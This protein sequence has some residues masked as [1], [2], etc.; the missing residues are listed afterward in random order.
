MFFDLTFNPSLLDSKLPAL[1]GPS[2]GYAL[3]DEFAKYMDHMLS[4]CSKQAELVSK[5]FVPDVHAMTMFLEKV[6]EDCISEYLNAVITAAKA[7]EGLIIYLH[8]IASS[9]YSCSQLINLLAKNP[10]GVFIEKDNLRKRVSDMFSPY[11]S[12]Y[13]DL[14]LDHLRKRCKTEIDKWDKR[15]Q[16][17]KV[18]VDDKKNKGM[19][20]SVKAM[21]MA[22]VALLGGGM[23][24]GQSQ[25]LLNDIANDHIIPDKKATAT[26]DIAD[27]SMNSLVSVELALHLM[28]TNKESLGRV[29]V[30]TANTDMTKLRNAVQK[31]F[32][33]LL[34]V[35]GEK[36]LKPAFAMY[37]KR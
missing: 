28:H 27:Q 20:G 32:V 29:L 14:E 21:V 4:N 35:L 11:M 18:A 24:R 8:S 23:K 30:I 37:D 10:Y 7:R 22:P 34:K 26:Y 17:S 5:V 3:A 6:F 12:T 2:M 1:T 25:P 9:I 19:M 31:V 16:K 15:G 13:L 33:L 36:H